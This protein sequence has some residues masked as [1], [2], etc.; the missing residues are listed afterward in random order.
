MAK[1]RA[2][3]PKQ[4]QETIATLLHENR[5]FKPS[6]IFTRQANANSQSVYQTAAKDP[7]RFWE[8]MASELVWRKKWTKGLAWN[9]PDAKWFVGGKLNVTESCLDR[10]VSSDAACHRNKAALIWEGEPG[11]KRVLTYWDLYR[12]VNK[13]GNALRKL[14]IKKG[15]RVAI[16]LP[17]IPE[18]IISVLACARIGA[19]HS[20]VFGGF[21]PKPF[22]TALTMLKQN[23]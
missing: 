21:S 6:A 17:M 11:D 16:Y 3:N 7:V 14:G 1:Q 10:H 19:V 18:L 13:F 5:T 22:A 12:A 15:D 4:A 2:R 8:K 9:P 20:V 23:Y